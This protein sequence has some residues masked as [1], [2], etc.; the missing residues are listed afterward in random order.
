MIG[1][2]HWAFRQAAGCYLTISL[3][4]LSGSARTTVRFGLALI[5]I[6]SPVSG[7]RPCRALVGAFSTRLILSKPGTLKMPGPPF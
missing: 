6:G 3:S 2:G 4:A 5:V 1:S 7:L